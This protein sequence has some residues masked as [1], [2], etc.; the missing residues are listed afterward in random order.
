MTKK[1][2]HKPTPRE[3]SRPTATAKAARGVERQRRKTSRQAANGDPVPAEPALH[4][5][6]NDDVIAKGKAVE[7]ELPDMPENA[8]A[9]D[10]VA[11]LEAVVG[12]TDDEEPPEK[13]EAEE[14][15][16]FLA[17]YFRDMA[18]LAVL[19]PQEEFASAR[20]IEGLEIAVWARILS[21]APAIDHVLKVCERTLENSLAEFKTLRT[22]LDVSRKKPTRP[23][24][25]KLERSVLKVAER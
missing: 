4:S 17:M 2:L 6:E 8:E 10:A 12:M 23:A 13:R 24:Q 22:N 1:T 5:D 19:R 9:P 3:I 25:E 7:A 18:R 14:P 15:S 11:E 21:Y 16:N 20:K